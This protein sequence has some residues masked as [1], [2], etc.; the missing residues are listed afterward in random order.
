[1]I[2][3]GMTILG[4]VLSRGVGGDV[5]DGCVRC[6]CDIS[7]IKSMGIDTKKYE[8]CDVYIDMLS[9]GIVGIRLF[10]D[11][12]ESEYI[13]DFT[14]DDGLEVRVPDRYQYIYQIICR[15]LIFSAEPFETL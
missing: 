7:V 5:E 4:A 9:C 6:G 1:M 10:D 13:F 8:Y 2:I 14:E 15:D 3:D 11:E 12:G